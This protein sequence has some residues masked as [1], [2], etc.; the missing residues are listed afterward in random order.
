M[1]M[2]IILQIPLRSRRHDDFWS[3]HYEW[4]GVFSV[5]SAYT[6]LVATR[7]R[8]E[9]WLDNRASSYSGELVEK[10]WSEHWRTRVPSKVKLFLLRLARQCL[11]IRGFF[12][13]QDF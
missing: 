5:R 8:R 6:M 1:D 4:K 13:G 3:W 2:D 10:L 7:E 9:A 11:P 12:L